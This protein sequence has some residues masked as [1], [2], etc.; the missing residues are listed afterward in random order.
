MF[1]AP[2]TEVAPSFFVLKIP[3]T[4]IPK[5]DVMQVLISVSLFDYA[6]VKSSCLAEWQELW[7]SR[8]NLEGKQ[9]LWG[10]L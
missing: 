1:F 8:I 4:K 3:K 9:L 2:S 7:A 10:R 6:V 5:F